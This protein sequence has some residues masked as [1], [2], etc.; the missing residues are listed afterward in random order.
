MHMRRDTKTREK[1]QN[2]D[3]SIT[4]VSTTKFLCTTHFLLLAAIVAYRTVLSYSNF[5][6]EF[7]RNKKEEISRI[8]LTVLFLGQVSL[9]IANA[10]MAKQS[11]VRFLEISTAR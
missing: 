9:R 11:N 4:D 2:G 3:T 1:L 6:R 7:N 5:L 8:Y 10:T